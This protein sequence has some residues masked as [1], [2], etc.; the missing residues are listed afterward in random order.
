MKDKIKGLKE[1]VRSAETRSA[2]LSAETEAIRNEATASKS[3]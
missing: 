1:K 3:V 2:T